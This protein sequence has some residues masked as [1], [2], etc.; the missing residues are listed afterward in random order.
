VTTTGGAKCWGYGVTGALGDG[1]ATTQAAPVDVAGLGSGVASISAGLAHTCA[2]TIEGGVFCWGENDDGQV[3]DGTITPRAA[4]VAVSGL[5]S[6]VIAVSAGDYHTCALTAEGGVRCWG[7]QVWGPTSEGAFTI[8]TTPG[9]ILDGGVGNTSISAGDHHSCI[10][11]APG[12]VKCWGQ[13]SYGQLGIGNIETRGSAQE[14]MDIGPGEVKPT[15]I[16]RMEIS[17]NGKSVREQAFNT[18]QATQRVAQQP[19]Q[20][21]DDRG[22]EQRRA[23]HRHE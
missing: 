2:L 21:V 6:G 8:W 15:R 11:T 16:H 1:S 17:I 12:G 23:N 14:V 20:P 3:G 7:L 19:R 22:H 5:S 4:P 13:N 10:V 18:E 9:P